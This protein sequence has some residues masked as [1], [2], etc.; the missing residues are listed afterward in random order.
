MGFYQTHSC[1]AWPRLVRTGPSGSAPQ[2]PRQFFRLGPFGGEN[3]GTLGG[4]E[5]VGGFL[6]G[7]QREGQLVEDVGTIGEF[8]GGELEVGNGEG[9][10][11]E[12][13]LGEAAKEV[14]LGVLGG[15][16]DHL[17]ET[18]EGL[19]ES[20]LIELKGGDAKGGG[21]KRR[22]GFQG[23]EIGRL[24]IAGTA[25]RFESSASGQVGLSACGF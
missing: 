17:I 6:R 5:G 8:F 19:V 7:F 15:Q 24:G 3:R 21:G 9:G 18:D 20:A 22:I 2:L 4:F 25:E 14:G 12:G 13:E 10:M 1:D 11:V 16:L 23:T